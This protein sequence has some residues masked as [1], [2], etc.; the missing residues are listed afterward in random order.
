MV[1][2]TQPMKVHAGRLERSLSGQDE[3]MP[4]VDIYEIEEGTTILRAEVPGATQQSIDIRVEKGVLSIAAQ[5]DLGEF[6]EEYT[7]TYTGFVGGRYFRVFALSDEVDREKIEAALADGVLTL[8][9]P[10]AAAAKT[11]KIEIKTS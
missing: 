3:L 5:A 9:L 10:R 1:D 4:L 11:R 7:R 2:R 8:R 6:A